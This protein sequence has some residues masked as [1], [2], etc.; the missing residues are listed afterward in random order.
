MCWWP[1]EINDTDP[2]WLFSTQLYIPC[3]IKSFVKP[4]NKYYRYPL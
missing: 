2:L 1:P 3:S 4:K